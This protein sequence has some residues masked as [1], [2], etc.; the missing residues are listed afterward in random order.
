MNKYSK[1]KDF[2]ASRATG[3][4]SSDIPILAGLSKRYGSTTLTLWQEKTGQ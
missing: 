4:G 1:I 2:H 3:V